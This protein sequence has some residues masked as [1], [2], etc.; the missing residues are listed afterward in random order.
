M[1][2]RAEAPAPPQG[3]SAQPIS[4]FDLSCQ[5]LFEARINSPFPSTRRTPGL[6]NYWLACPGAA[7]SAAVL[8]QDGELR[9]WFVLSRVVG[10]MRIADLWVDSNLVGDWA[11]GFS[12]AAT[13][14]LQDPCA[15]ELVASVS[16]PVAIDAA[17]LAG[18]RLRHTDTIFAL[19]HKNLL[20][21][22]PTLNVTPVESDLGYLQ[23]PSYPY[24]T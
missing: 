13:A 22:A 2:S 18:F 14:A 8:R 3:W 11:A 6:M 19:D 21:T 23:D 16:I 20:G 17:S 9:G 15:F 10:Q 1:W 4:K 24:L 12:L 7:M 5:P